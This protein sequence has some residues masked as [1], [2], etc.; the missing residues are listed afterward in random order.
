MISLPTPSPLPNVRKIFIPDQGKSF[1]DIDLDSADL[2]IVAGESNCV[3]LRQM[4]DAGLKPYVE[5][6]K[7][8]FH[9]QSITKSHP[10][11]KTFKG[12]CHAT[13]YLG[14][15]RGIAPRVGLVVAE[16]E[17]IQ[18]WYFGKFPEV[19]AWQDDIIHRI[20]KDKFITNVFGYRINVF[21]RISDA[22]YRQLVA[23][24]PQS[25]VACLINRGYLNIY[26]NLREVEVLLQVHDSLAGQFDSF[27]G[28]WAKRRIVEECTI[29]LPYET[30][31]IIPVGIKVSK[32]S[33]GHCG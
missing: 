28:D 23:W 16:V 11:Y 18:Q 25:T 15:A 10:S 22:L 12:L 24:I 7:E 4:F 3:E 5:V 6:A 17:R 27:H 33:W 29:P 26:R 14:R 21:D 8:Y 20:N 1:F 32:E 9:D 30:P 31:L 19:K 2:R 13:N